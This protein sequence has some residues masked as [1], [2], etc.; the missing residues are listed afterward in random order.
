MPPSQPVL[1][2]LPQDLITEAAV[3]QQLS[4]ETGRAAASVRS[5][6]RRHLRRVGAPVLKVGLTRIFPV[7]ALRPQA[8]SVNEAPRV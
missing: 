4:L 6:L 1:T 7:A 5:A 2:A 3:V 8:A